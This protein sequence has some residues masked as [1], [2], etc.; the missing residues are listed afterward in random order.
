M[1]DGDRTHAHRHTQSEDALMGERQ[2]MHH[3]FP[4]CLSFFLSLPVAPEEHT[5]SVSGVNVPLLIVLPCIYWL[6]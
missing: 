4:F 2:Q 3:L 6:W 5:I 1:N